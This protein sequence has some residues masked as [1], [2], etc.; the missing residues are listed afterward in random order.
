MTGRARITDATWYGCAESAA[1]TIGR[2]DAGGTD[3]ALGG[4]G[5]C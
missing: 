4:S 5:P 2:V 3:H 1:G